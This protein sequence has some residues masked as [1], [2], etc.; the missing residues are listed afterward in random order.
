M[1]RCGVSRPARRRASRATQGRTEDPTHVWH[2]PQPPEP[3]LPPQRQRQA[4][5]RRRPS[6]DAAA[7]A[8]PE[9][10]APVKSVNRP[11]LPPGTVEQL[12]TLILKTIETMPPL[13]QQAIRILR[14][15][16]SDKSSARSV[17]ELASQDPIL[18]A[19][20][21][22]TAN[23]RGLQHRHP[24]RRRAGGDREPGLLGRPHAHAAD[25]ARQPGGRGRDGHGPGRAVD[26][27][28]G[29]QPDR[30]GAG[31]QVR[32]RPAAVQHARP[33]PRPGQAGR[34][35]RARSDLRDAAWPSP[36]RPAKGEIVRE[37]RVLGADH[38]DIG[39]YV[40]GPVA[41]AAGHRRG[42]PL[43]P[44]PAP[45]ARGPVRGRPPQ[46]RGRRQRRQRAEQVPPRLHGRHRDLP[47]RPRR[48]RHAEH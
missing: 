33:A 6:G 9:V 23:S 12:N 10:V 13:P 38:A 2:L 22:R 32:C 41:A 28:H 19:G 31:H 14:E 3:V 27:R 47:D 5:L 18:A 8:K 20:I 21:L 1:P 36:G 24:G 42:H 29:R 40:A 44:Q 7:P 34:P 48:V 39:A 25:E 17:A 16:N 4:R 43:P 46:G 30:R 15:L 11:A 35:P 26:P 45:D 37:R